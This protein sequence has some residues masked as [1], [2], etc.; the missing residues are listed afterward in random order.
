MAAQQFIGLDWGTSSVRAYLFA[1]DGRMLDQR[2]ADWGVMNLPLAP[3]AD[4]AQREGRFSHAFWQ[5]A[6]D[7]LRQ[8]G[9]SRR[10][11]ACGMVGSTQGWREAGYIPVPVTIRD[12]AGALTTFPVGEGASL[13]IA[14]GLLQRGAM[15]DAIRGEE[16]QIAGVPA[17]LAA[18]GLTMEG[19]WLLGLPG[20]HSKWAMVRDGAIQRFDTFL[21]GELY[22]LLVRHSILGRSM[23]ETVLDP[24]SEA[25]RQAFMLGARNACSEAGRK[26][27]LGTIFSSRSLSLTNEL[28]GPQQREYLS[29][30]LLG[31]EI[32]GLL[33]SLQAEWRNA[34]IAL[35][36]RPGLCQRYH[37]VLREH[38][39]AS[40]IL[41]EEA[42][43]HGLWA[44]I[45]H[46]DSQPFQE[47]GTTGPLASS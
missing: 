13:S 5:L 12:I 23:G 22:A 41:S 15:P 1:A 6:G 25:S 31:H 24:D 10:V 7:W 3:G 37:D 32:S 28:T 18:K 43:I 27:L 35:I 9:T 11:T 46:D 36:G 26:G 30:L 33:D 2:E 8:P 4:P 44:L 38:G 19:H 21:T 47:D 42:G 45:R 29:G 40:E 39:H 16:T 20:T 14:P 17:L 34:R